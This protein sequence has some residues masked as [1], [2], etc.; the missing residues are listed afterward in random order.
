[1]RK[2][3]CK[4][5]QSSKFEKLFEVDRHGKSYTVVK[6]INC[7]LIFVNPQPS[8]KEIQA[9]YKKNYDYSYMEE[10]DNNNHYY[11]GELTLLEKELGRKGRI[12]D[13]GC[14]AG[15]F[16]ARAQKRGWK[17]QGIEL[18]SKIASFGRKN[19]GIKIRT[20]NFNQFSSKEKFDVITMHHFMEH[21]RDP[22]R[23][24][25][26]ANR[27]LKKSGLFLLSTPNINSF[28]AKISAKRW[29]W[30]SPPAHLFFFSKKNLRELLEKSNF[31][32]VKVRTIRKD[33]KPLFL[34]LINAGLFRL[35]LWQLAK[36]KVDE[37]KKKGR[38]LESDLRKNALVRAINLVF[39][40]LNFFLNEIGLG[41]ELLILAQ[42][43]ESKNEN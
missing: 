1:M 12:L 24:L 2:I 17:V 15:Q 33:A 16:L 20:S 10:T 3:N 32:L 30:L 19:F 26:K 14:G 21:V 36:K 8:Q 23:C 39:Y 29:E 22:S 43:R 38:N 27:L 41:P 25:L 42:K 4:L 9:H 7:D 40:P 35:G 18:S 13:V 34:S 11:A 5:C 28:D 37:E 31:K 6:C